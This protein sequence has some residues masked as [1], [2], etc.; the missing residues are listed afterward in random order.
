VNGKN[1]ISFIL[2]HKGN[3]IIVMGL[4]EE[5]VFSLKERNL[6]LS[7]R[8]KDLFQKSFFFDKK[9]TVVD[10]FCVLFS[11]FDSF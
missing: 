7:D 6:F 10:E 11:F 9:C 2:S 1:N 3:N 4:R 5:V 8:L